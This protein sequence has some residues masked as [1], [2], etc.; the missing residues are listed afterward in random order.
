MATFHYTCVF[1]SRGSKLS[2]IHMNTLI[3]RL[4]AQITLTFCTDC[5]DKTSRESAYAKLSCLDTEYSA[6]KEYIESKHA[7]IIKIIIIC[8]S[9][10][11]YIVF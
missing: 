5:Q 6:L 7:V 11:V 8:F 2:M 3:Y 4:V 9:N 10:Y 1:R